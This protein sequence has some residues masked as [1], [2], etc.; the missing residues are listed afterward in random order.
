[1][2]YKIHAPF[3]YADDM[4]NYIDFMLSTFE[5]NID[6]KLN[7]LAGDNEPLV[8]KLK[9]AYEIAFN[10]EEDLLYFKLKYNHR[11]I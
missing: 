10:N 1:M 7:S 5:Y 11:I 8:T 6:Y 9:F 4:S 2:K 3:L